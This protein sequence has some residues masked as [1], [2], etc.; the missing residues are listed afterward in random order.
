MSVYYRVV[1]EHIASI[2]GI[3]DYRKQELQENLDVVFITLIL[4]FLQKNIPPYLFTEFFTGL[5]ELSESVEPI[6]K[7][8]VRWENFVIKYLEQIPDYSDRFEVFCDEQSIISLLE[9]IEE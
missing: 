1:S 7:N 4:K 2:E 5:K 8:D 9:A 3:T 6:S